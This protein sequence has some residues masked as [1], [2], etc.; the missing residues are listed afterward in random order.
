MNKLWRVEN[1]QLQETEWQTRLEDVNE[2]HASDEDWKWW[3]FFHEMVAN[4]HHHL[5]SIPF[6]IYT[7]V[8][9]S[10]AFNCRLHESKPML[11]NSYRVNTLIVLLCVCFHVSSSSSNDYN[12]QHLQDIISLCVCVVSTQLIFKFSKAGV[13]YFSYSYITWIPFLVSS[14]WIMGKGEIKWLI[15]SLSWTFSKHFSVNTYFLLIR[16]ANRFTNVAY[17]QN[18][19]EHWTKSIRWCV[20]GFR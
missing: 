16:P 10:V 2:C 5:L 15:Y 7:F 13:E 1:E 11:S 14:R 4:S 19:M 9:Y 8:R 12:D 18:Q 3:I 6:F 17:K 20:R